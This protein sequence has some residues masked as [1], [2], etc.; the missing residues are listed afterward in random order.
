MSA[1]LLHG[2]R[3]AAIGLSALALA[4][5]GLLAPA[6]ASP[7]DAA[8]PVRQ[9]LVGGMGS[10]NI[11]SLNADRRGTLSPV[12]GSPFAVKEGTGFSIAVSHDGKTVY[13]GSQ[14]G[15]IT[16][17]EIRSDGT[18]S[19][20][21][22]AT[23]DTA[24]VAV[25]G[26]TVSPDGKRL[27][28]TLTGDNEGEVRSY[29]IGPSGDLAPTGAPAV[30]VPTA[31]LSLPVISPDGRY[32]YVSSAFSNT[33][34]PFAI[35]SD[36]SLTPVGEP[37]ET[38]AV[39]ALPA[40][41]PDGRFLYVSNEQDKSQSGFRIEED[42]SL[43]PLPGSPYPTGGLPH[44]AAITADSKRL[45]IPQAADGTV[46]GF[47]IEDSGALTPLPGSPYPARK[48]G[49]PGLTVL[50]PD[51]KR[52]FIVEVASFGLTAR[53]YTY[54]VQDDGSLT[55]TGQPLV[56]TKTLFADGPTAVITPNQGPT[57]AVRVVGSEG[58]TTTFSAAGS[59]DSDGSIARYDWDFGDGT[60]ETTTTP[61]VTHT[62]SGPTT[63]PVT[64]TV[65]DDENCSTE[66][67]YT[68]RV[69]TCTGG[70]QATAAVQ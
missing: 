45:Y 13:S 1:K 34:F 22:G 56:D 21:P 68:G 54:V 11:A 30:K 67:V 25:I 23:V 2:S 48:D 9:L 15:G 10:G 40:I 52:L 12:P 4:S 70:P 49:M 59:T 7:E 28:A 55:P 32:L 53:A 18:L 5:T 26:L 44:G 36:A 69:A 43:T 64:V 62:F 31:T 27:F 16:G 29:A 61:E 46:T 63:G 47:A 58:A 14:K 3:R 17:H 65:T 38:G 33:I 50:S 24:G 60:T 35:A 57:A 6:S 8:A 20:R 37:V 41:T 19:Q 39:A 51:G 66:L 42:G